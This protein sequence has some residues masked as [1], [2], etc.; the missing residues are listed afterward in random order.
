MR[1]NTMKRIAAGLLALLLCALCLPG[2]AEEYRELK[3]GMSGEDVQRLKKAMY[4]LGYFTTENL[5]GN[6]TKTTAERVM[7]LQK[8]N[9]LPETGVAD[10]ALQ[11]LVFSGNAVKTKTAPNPSP[12]A[13]P[14]PTPKPPLDLSDVLPPRTE[15]GF[16]TADAGTEE[17]VYID[18][19]EGVWIYLTPSL[20]IDV[21][22]Y[23]TQK[24]LLVWYEADIHCSPE[25]PLVAYTNGEKSP[26]ASLINPI[27]FVKE[28]HIVLGISDDHFGY[29]IAENDKGIPPGI[30]IREGKII[31]TKTRTK[32]S[33]PNL[34]ILAMFEDGSM[35]CFEPQEYTAEEYLA[36]GVKTTYAFG[37]ALV[38]NGELTEYMLRKEYYT[39]HEPRMAMGMIEPYHYIIL[40]VEGRMDDRSQ[41]VYLTWLADKMIE[42]GAVEALNLDGGGTSILTF[43]GV[44][45]NKKSDSVR[46][47]GSMTGFGVSDLVPEK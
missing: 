1:G 8:N 4:W 32:E 19:D 44:R 13:T 46:P 39:Y 12:V 16:L 43:M 7:Q 17:Y 5:D 22:R 2:F 25:T 18:E 38:K 45:L 24:P 42:K 10:A 35:K 31:T 29:R 34:D 6:Y 15:E 26:G 47:V 28:R 9:G 33:L 23:Q 30:I 11:E 36:M 41:G 37:P 20:S 21:R 40:C 27:T 14:A 3:Q